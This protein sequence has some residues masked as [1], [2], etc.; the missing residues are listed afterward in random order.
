MHDETV[1][2]LSKWRTGKHEKLYETA[3]STQ[4]VLDKSKNVHY[5]FQNVRSQQNMDCLFQ[6]MSRNRMVAEVKLSLPIGDGNTGYSNKVTR[7][8]DIVYVRSY[9]TVG[10]PLT[11]ILS[12][13]GPLRRN[14]N[15]GRIEHYKSLNFLRAIIC[16]SR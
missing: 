6:V 8:H 1:N 7:W 12:S 15:Y 5:C 3:A 10:R 16:W 2:K 4:Y 9:F 13:G 14:I 11:R